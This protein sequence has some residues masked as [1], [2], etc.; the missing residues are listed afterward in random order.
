MCWL[1]RLF[2]GHTIYSVDIV[3]CTSLFIY[4]GCVCK[5][6][7]WHFKSCWWKGFVI[8][9]LENAIGM[10]HHWADQMW[11]CRCRCIAVMLVGLKD[12]LSGCISS[13]KTENIWYCCL[14][15]ENICFSSR[16]LHHFEWSMGSSSVFNHPEKLNT[17][18]LPKSQNN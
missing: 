6:C 11:Q 9:F 17:T 16:R 14:I 4:C 13:R 8:H 5:L 7:H 12:S 2:K 1:W 3:F 10:N 15:I 18:E